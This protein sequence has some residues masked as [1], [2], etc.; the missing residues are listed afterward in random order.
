[1]DKIEKPSR[2]EFSDLIYHGTFSAAWSSK[3]LS[4]IQAYVD[5]RGLQLLQCKISSS[6][7]RRSIILAVTQYDAFSETDPKLSRGPANNFQDSGLEWEARLRPESYTRVGSR[8]Q[9]RTELTQ[10]Q[11]CGTKYHTLEGD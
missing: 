5:R 3:P 2:V 9:L 4:L 10:R 8:P 6:E 1:M 11:D 7:L